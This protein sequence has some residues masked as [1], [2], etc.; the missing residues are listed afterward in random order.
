MDVWDRSAPPF[1]SQ[2]QMYHLAT[3]DECDDLSE[4]IGAFLTQ[5]GV[6]VLVRHRGADMEQALNYKPDRQLGSGDGW[7][8]WREP[9]FNEQVEPDG[10]RVLDWVLQV[11][12]Q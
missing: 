3:T 2:I 10:D 6:P 5:R 4:K 1:V 8:L 7:V 9:P 12:A 11:A